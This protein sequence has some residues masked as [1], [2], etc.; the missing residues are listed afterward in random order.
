MTRLNILASILEVAF[1][2]IGV[3]AGKQ[4][5]QQRLPGKIKDNHVLGLPC[6]DNRCRL[7]NATKH[8]VMEGWQLEVSWAVVS[9]GNTAKAY[10]AA[11]M[12]TYFAWNGRLPAFRSLA[13]GKWIRGN[14]DFLGKANACEGELE[15]SAW[16]PFLGADVKAIP[17]E[18]G[19]YRIRAVPPGG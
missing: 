4:G 14:E 12:Q 13:S 18:P 11:L 3:G 16:T 2:D 9:N 5:L 10:E 8:A 6:P 7:N 17:T 15:W 19:V 1:V